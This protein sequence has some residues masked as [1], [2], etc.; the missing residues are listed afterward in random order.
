[1]KGVGARRQG[2][3]PLPPSFRLP[4]RLRGTGR[5]A[6][7]SCQPYSVVPSPGGTGRRA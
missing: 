3:P 6:L 7:F 2:I 5:Q 1:M 4:R